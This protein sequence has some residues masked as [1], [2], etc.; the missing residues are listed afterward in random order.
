MHTRKDSGSFIIDDG[1]GDGKHG[2]DAYNHTGES[3][4]DFAAYS[5]DEIKSVLDR[6]TVM[7]KE[8]P[9]AGKMEL[10]DMYIMQY[11]DEDDDESGVMRVIP[12]LTHLL[13]EAIA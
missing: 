6:L 8:N 4:S 9:K 2:E 1:T 13:S 12:L 11:H 7:S 5:A 3:V 10:G